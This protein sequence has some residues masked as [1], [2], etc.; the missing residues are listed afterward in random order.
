MSDMDDIKK[1]DPYDRVDRLKKL[2]KER[3][4]EME[5]A[6]KLIDDAVK[7]I[8]SLEELKEI[9]IPQ[10]KAVDIE[11]LF[12]PEEKEV[13]KAKRFAE[14]QNLEEMIPQDYNPDYDSLSPEEQAEILTGA[15]NTIQELSEAEYLSSSEQERLESYRTL[16]DE[17]YDSGWEP[18]EDEKKMLQ[19]ERLMF[20]G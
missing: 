15:Y 13:F 4:K 2:K 10:I 5:E 12:T 20:G 11:S 6:S 9:P 16:S 18:E 19:A 14:E 3:E 17:L 1:L 8:E 7:E